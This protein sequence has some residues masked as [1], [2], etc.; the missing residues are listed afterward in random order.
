MTN[1]LRNGIG[2][3]DGRLLLD[4]L[5]YVSR[6][7]GSTT[8]ELAKYL[9]VSKPTIQRMLRNARKQ[10]GVRITYKKL[11]QPYVAAGEFTVEH[12]GVFDRAR[13]RRFVRGRRP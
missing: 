8:K 3:V 4:T 11:N 10:F 5:D 12:W 6:E 7:G 2:R 9:K 13:V 1:P